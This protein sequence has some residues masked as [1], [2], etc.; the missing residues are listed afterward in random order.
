MSGLLTVPYHLL[1]SLWAWR[2][3]GLEFDNKIL[4]INF[5]TENATPQR[6][7]TGTVANY[8]CE[9]AKN[10]GVL[11]VAETP[12]PF[13]DIASSIKGAP[14]ALLADPG[15]T[16]IVNNFSIIRV[17]T[18]QS[19]SYRTLT[20]DN[21]VNKRLGS[22]E[23]VAVP[24]AALAYDEAY[25][26]SYSGTLNGSAISKTFTFKTMPKP[27]SIVTCRNPQTGEIYQCY[28]DTMERV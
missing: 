20:V 26:V 21:D 22:N 5:G 25:Q 15:S 7:G 2:S 23:F 18:G 12:N 17:S 13:P 24:I 11:W 19:E 3:A 8:P 27:R 1:G 28:E 14:V 16:L 10:V 6:L 9:G 4:T